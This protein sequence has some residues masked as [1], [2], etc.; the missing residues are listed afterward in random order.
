MQRHEFLRPL[1][2]EHHHTLRLARDL[3]RADLDA[4]HAQR[5]LREAAADLSR[6]FTDEEDGFAAL[7][8]EMP[9]NPPVEALLDRMHREHRALSVLIDLLIEGASVP[10]KATYQTL[11]Q[12]LAEHI[13]FEERCLFPAL[14]GACQVTEV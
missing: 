7:M 4:A 6:H 14:Q 3:Q 12:L 2:R 13:A 11:G 10:A 8:A 1:S 5:R 9:E